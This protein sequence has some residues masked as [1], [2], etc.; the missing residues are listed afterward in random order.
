MSP[1]QRLVIHAHCYQ[2]PREDPWLDLVPREPNA[3]PDHDWNARI[4]REC[5]A[6]LGAAPVLG[7]DGAVRRVINCWEWLS[8]DV[9]PTLV[10]WL[11]RHAPTALGAMV[12][13]DAAAVARSGHGTALAAPYNHVILPLASRSDK[14]SEVRW[15]IRDF[16]RVFHRDPRGMWLP[17]TAVDEETL[18]VL[19][20]EGITFTLLAPHQV[21]TPD[22]LGA[23]LVWHGAGRELTIVPYHGALSHGVAFGDLLGDAEKFHHAIRDDREGALTVIATDGETFGHHH[24]FG[25][26]AVAALLDRVEHDRT[27]A[28][29]TLEEAAATASPRAEA[30]L[31]PDSSWSCPHG[32]GRWRENCGCRMDPATSQEW[33]VPL[34]AG[35]EALSAALLPIIARRGDDALDR[36]RRAMFTSCGWFFDDLA[37]IEP[38]IVL[39]QAARALDLV[40]DPQERG[41]LE[42]MLVATLATARANDPADGTGA[43]IWEERIVVGRPGGAA[44]A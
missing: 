15:G 21:A 20:E 6:P 30:L 32:L 13:G 8:F 29:T 5:Y 27:M 44:T 37:R 25:D 9:G 28:M 26:L 43:T 2:P 17:E 41:R 19:A 7:T 24:R 22:P 14:V 35:L 38:A 10:R 12:A 3:A 40:P 33:R 39:R 16:R 23:P 42:A 31:I 11:E 18:T 34:R 36:F 4:T 1:L